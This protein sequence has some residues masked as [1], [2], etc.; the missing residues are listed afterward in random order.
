LNHPD[1]QSNVLI[2]ADRPA[3]L[4]RLDASLRGCGFTVWLASGPDEA[5]DVL[6]SASGRIGLAL[7]ALSPL[8]AEALAKALC[9]A[10]PGLLYS[11]LDPA[12][13]PGEYLSFGR[14]VEDLLPPSAPVPPGP[15]EEI[16]PGFP[17][18]EP[19]SSPGSGP[20]EQPQRAKDQVKAEGIPPDATP[21]AGGPAPGR[22][23]MFSRRRGRRARPR[24]G[25]GFLVCR[26]GGAGRNLALALLDV[27]ADGARLQLSESLPAGT[28][29][30]LTLPGPDRPLQFS[31]VVVWSRAGPDGNYLAG[32]MLADSIAPDDLEWLTRR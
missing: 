32:L 1:S 21:A 27:S 16:S 14:R 24:L 19:G 17:L 10:R 13:P 30:S 15:G 5:L 3:D 22:R 11:V 18:P 9:D 31:A 7:L 26:K 20:R 25:A 23:R 12:A 29:V 2:V 6:R 8:A 4:S 28:E